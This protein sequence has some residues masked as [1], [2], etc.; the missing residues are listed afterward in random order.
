MHNFSYKGKGIRIEQ[1][2][3]FKLDKEV[4]IREGRTKEEVGSF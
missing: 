1:R 3:N 2:I 4:L